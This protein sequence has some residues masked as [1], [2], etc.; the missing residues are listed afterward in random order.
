MEKPD[1]K[2]ALH[3]VKFIEILYK[4]IKFRESATSSNV[5]I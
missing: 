3:Q 5:A 1:N 4:L 2:V